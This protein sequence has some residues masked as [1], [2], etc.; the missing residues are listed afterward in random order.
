MST[1]RGYTTVAHIHETE[2]S[3]VVRAKRESDGLSVVLKILK[4]AY[5]SSDRLARFKQEYERLRS[6]QMPGVIGV[7][8]LVCDQ[9]IWAIVQ[10]DIGGAA[11]ANFIASGKRELH[12]LLAI[13]IHI[14]ETLGRV[15]Q[16]KVI[17]K[18]LNPS[19]IVYNPATRDLRIIDFGISTVLSRQT[20]AITSPEVLEG[21][22]PYISPEQTGRMNRSI[23]YRTDF[24]SLGVV[25]YE[26]F[27]GVLPFTSHDPMELVHCHIAKQPIPPHEQDRNVPRA[28]SGIIMKLMGKT[29]ESRYQSTFGIKADLLACQTALRERGAIGDM[30]LGTQ[31][32]SEKFQ[33][34]QRLYGREREIEALIGA[35]ER[36][37]GHGAD[38]SG[39][40]ELL[41]ISGPSGI[42]KSAVVQELY[43]PVTGRRGYFIAG[44]FDQFHGAAPYSAF[45][46]AFQELVHQVLAESEARLNAVRE[47]LLS[48]LGNNAA[49]LLEILPEVTHI[50]GQQPPVPALGPTE[51]QSRFRNAILNFI[52]VFARAEHPL[53]LFLDDLQR[54]DAGSLRLLELIMRDD[55]LQHFLFV[56]AYR[57][58]EVSAAHPLTTVLESLANEGAFIERLRL[59]PLKLS[60]I[61]E[62]V[63]ATV[64]AELSAVESLAGLIMRKTD[65]NPFFVSEFLKEIHHQRLLEF[66]P[67]Q[68]RWKWDIVQIE[69]KGMTDNVVD[70]MIDKLRRLPEKTRD[71]LRL[72]ACI[73]GQFDSD[74]LA[75]VC[76]TDAGSEV[77]ADPERA[78]AQRLA[79]TFELLLPALDVGF[80]IASSELSVVSA[81]APLV[82]RDF[83]FLHD[84]VQQAAYALIEE[85][86]RKSVH[87]RIA[88]LL[89]AALKDDAR[90]G[91]L[92]SLA[93]QWNR[94]GD[95]VTELGERIA[96]A[97][98]NLAAG[99]R[100]RVS[101]A[102]GAA[103]DYLAAGIRA[104]GED[105]IQ[106]K[107]ALALPL[108]RELTNAEYL[109]G[110]HARAEELA[111]ATIALAPTA[112]ERADVYAMIVSQY[113]ML[114][115]YAEAVD[116]AR[117][118]LALL[119]VD[120]PVD[121]WDAA[122]QTELALVNENM[123]GRDVA[124]LF[125]RP[126][127][128]DPWAIVATRLLIRAFALAFYV[129]PSLYS[130]IIFKAVNFSLRYGNPTEGADLFPF[131]GHLVSGVLGQHRV[132]YEFGLLGLRLS[133][134]AGRHGDACRS[135]F[136]LA[137]FIHPWVHPLWKALPINDT[138]YQ[139]GVAA[140]E[141]QFGGYILIYKL[142]NQFYEGKPI[143]LVLETLPA[144]LEF[145]KRGNNQI[146]VDIILGIE[147]VLTNL[148]REVSEF[149]VDS[150]TEAAYLAACEENKSL[151]AIAYYHTLKMQALYLRGDNAGALA[152]SAI[153]EKL[154]PVIMGN[155]A[156]GEHCFYTALCHAAACPDE[157][158]EKREQM[159]AQLRESA[160][161][162]RRYA[163]DNPANFAHM[164]ALAE[165]EIARLTGSPEAIDHYDRAIDTAR[166]HGFPQDEALA[167]ELCGR[168][169][170]ERKKDRIARSYLSEAF[171]GYDRWGCGFM[172]K[173]RAARYPSL[174][175]TDPTT[176][177][178]GT[179]PGVSR[180]S[181]RAG[182]SF[183]LMSVVKASQAISSEIVL[184]KLFAKLIRII[185]ENAGAERGLLLLEERGELLV[186]VEAS[187]TAVSEDK[188]PG[189][190]VVNVFSRTPY[191]H[192]DGLAK[193][194]IRYVA[195][196]RRSVILTD[197]AQE[198]EFTR[199]A[200]VVAHGTK[201]VLCA[202]IIGRG[203]LIGILYG[204]N[205]LTAGA[206]TQERLDVLKHLSAQIAISI[207]N[208]RL[209]NEM[210]RK[211][212]ERTEDL[213]KKNVDL[214]AALLHLKETQAQLV[215]QAKLAS[216]GQLTAGI[217]HEIKNP[218][219]FVNNFAE[220]NVELVNEL[221]EESEEDP[222]TTLADVIDTF[223]MLK[224]NSQ[225]IAEHGKRA[226]G[227]VRSMM[228]HASGGTGERRRMDVNSLVEEYVNLAFHGM[229]A[230]DKESEVTIVREYA[231]DAGQ[232]EMLPQEIG[233]VLVN[234]MNNA[235][236]AVRERKKA[237]KIGYTPT[238]VISTRR[239][240]G[241][242][243]IGVRDNGN[244]VPPEVKEMIFMP[245]YT[246]KPTGQGTGLGLSMSFEIVVQGH[247]GQLR[248]QDV[249]G[250][251]AHFIVS[252][253]T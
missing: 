52:R 186:S 115:K 195:R 92:F 151:M 49:L 170:V 125:D 96:L 23:D 234:L 33:I 54:A 243:S 160:D 246:T 106:A 76:Q 12:E 250:K 100:A 134:R 184:D 249:E 210:E 216:L 223:A 205:N 190:P 95:L 97:E 119:G 84:R 94:A 155:I 121:G 199:D 65:G 42:G 19:N 6:L 221:V 113:T 118:G 72:A 120:L 126:E 138:G 224:T 53:V 240:G 22:I 56:G 177:M 247:R 73:G 144:Y 81:D 32:N 35:F 201:S 15:H 214:Q 232:V 82:V 110:N 55:E 67:A 172:H 194:V 197:A 132:G 71:A 171:Y 128:D 208:A 245:F 241:H 88:R 59:T 24:Y 68:G 226:D 200:Y 129:N 178:T 237:E 7:L 25:L 4:P 187:V 212:E 238:I 175:F 78:R 147:M 183:D 228:Q 83:K 139:S 230:H 137:N 127:M 38:A 173:E 185:I 79:A 161:K 225:K 219:N 150:L 61:T 44:K 98:L 29:A 50:I 51:A 101:L 20:Q 198:G 140:G 18:D 248:L 34:P 142:M 99:R 156:V 3:E 116:A 57:D 253:P 93:D 46:Q 149:R 174:P 220:L 252:L 43:R 104:L 145:N 69:A 75:R 143:P 91:R 2:G 62:L 1:I 109:V 58:G 239:Q 180:S 158:G 213:R 148:T 14:V 162:L 8:D 242:V 36:V 37:V 179:A 251:G 233:R 130:L 188:Q 135:A 211:V 30:V 80:L 146:A 236:Y 26:I 11:L 16:A 215:E 196:T 66:D 227:I 70:L 244:G 47:E 209:Y 28:I 159:L 105:G 108:H 45:V 31:D 189:M 39:R 153:A 191:T 21:T 192:Y 124:S 60:H 157:P 10:E 85:N 102:Y 112:V 168:W 123:K 63:A 181:H 165:A 48:A 114:A 193:G 40:P 103:R 229:R 133:E 111:K 77:D 122:M 182:N 17:H 41:L 164:H 152:S 163:A 89:T 207:E 5:P 217:A 235:F 13:A 203:R 222:D 90:E 136:V 107:P 206:F 218:L 166:E 86:D 27:T 9:H 141:L 131:Y 176:S 74:T 64:N 117:T 231:P 154:L 202:P 87:L 167:N 204:E 169:W